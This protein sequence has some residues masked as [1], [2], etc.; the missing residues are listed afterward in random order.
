[1]KLNRMDITVIACVI[2]KMATV[3]LTA[4]F[5]TLTATITRASIEN[6]VVAMERNVMINLFAKLQ[7]TT[8]IMLLMMPA[9]M[10]TIYFVFRGRVKP[11]MLDFYVYFIVFSTV[12]N[13]LSDLGAVVALLIKAGIV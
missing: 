13:F 8:A 7:G 4:F 10:F 1:M 6:V 3:F 2:V 12:A 5:F 9:L 11:H